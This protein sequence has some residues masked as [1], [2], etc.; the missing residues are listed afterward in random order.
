LVNFTFTSLLRHY[1]LKPKNGRRGKMFYVKTVYVA[2]SYRRPNISKYKTDDEA[3]KFISMC[4]KWG[5]GIVSC[6]IIDREIAE[7]LLLD[8]KAEM[9]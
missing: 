9:G 4:L 7:Q 3:A 8:G 2:S 6:E 1:I 5:I